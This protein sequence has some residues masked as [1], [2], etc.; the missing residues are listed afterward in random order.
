MGIDYP[1]ARNTSPGT[2]WKN[3]LPLDNHRHSGADPLAADISPVMLILQAH[4]Q[5]KNAWLAGC[6]SID[7][8]M[9][10]TKRAHFE[11]ID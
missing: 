10:L 4:F 8:F 5:P 9:T 6:S 1:V 11:W 7:S 2:N 3:I